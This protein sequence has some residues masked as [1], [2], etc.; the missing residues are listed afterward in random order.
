[1]AEP[2]AA[3]PPGSAALS[4]GWVPL[5]APS[6]SVALRGISSAPSG[7]EKNAPAARS[8]GS[9]SATLLVS[10][11]AQKPAPVAGS[12]TGATRQFGAVPA[13]AGRMRLPTSSII[14]ITRCGSPP[15]GPVP[16]T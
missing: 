7:T 1:M 2:G 16:T 10:H 9:P 14:T 15:P 12:I 8:S 4:G 13:G 11:A 6:A 5:T 3:A